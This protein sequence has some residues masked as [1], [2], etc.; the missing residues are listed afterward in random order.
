MPGGRDG[1]GVSHPGLRESG[2]GVSS[3]YR[4]YFLAVIVV[5]SGML[6]YLWG[7][8]K[9]M[10]QG[11]A[12]ARLINERK[13]LLRHRDHLNARVARLKQ[14]SRIREIATEK[15]GMVFPEEPPRNLYLDPGLS[16][17]KAG[18]RR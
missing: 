13:A 10:G 16:D 8:V 18:I 15:L 6:I 5:V 2:T 3:P 4:T 12:Q 14:S 1:N 11:Q 7:H 17:S 9:T